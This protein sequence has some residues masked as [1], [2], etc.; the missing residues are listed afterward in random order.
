[1]GNH[2]MS[3][4]TKRGGVWHIDK[5]FRGT[6]IRESTAT[7]NLAK[8]QE[9][10]ARRIDQIR[11]ARIYG[12]RL[13]RTFRAAATRFLE[14]NQDKRT[15][16]EDARL[17]NWLDPVIGDLALKQVHMGSLQAFIAKRKAEGAKSRTINNTLALI[18]HILNLA[19]SEWRDEQGLTWLEHAPKIKL[20]PV[21]D[22]RAPY[23]LSREEQALLFQELP[24][25]L[26]RMALFKVNTGCRDQ[27]VCGLKWDDEVKVPELDTSVFTIPGDRVKNAQDRL[28]VL[29]R[30]ARSV[31]EAQRGQHPDHV[32]TIV[33]K[34]GKAE[35]GENQE[36]PTPVPI[37]RMNTSARKSA[38]VR[39]ADK[40]EE[41][42][43]SPAPEGF[44]RVRV[45]DLKHTFGRRLRAAGVSFEDRQ[46]LLGHKSQRITTHYSHPEPSNLIAAAEK[47][48]DSES[49]NS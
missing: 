24:D 48:C 15:I 44:R 26:A 21:R 30:I 1:M 4:L 13:D 2:R 28:V 34:R 17:L 33:P 47:V 8:A 31:V 41:R 6:R 32:F 35:P 10:L 20:I 39:A 46:D 3:G 36:A 7:D 27:E 45:H 40:W 29:N 37:F 5:M 16:R 43:G 12:V 49:R 42:T 18:R 25:H 38:R 14:E 22:G 11:S 9:Q 19:A 23:P